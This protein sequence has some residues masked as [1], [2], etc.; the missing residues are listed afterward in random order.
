MQDRSSGSAKAGGGGASDASASSS[1]EIGEWYFFIIW[2][3]YFH[4]SNLC[5]VNIHIK[6]GQKIIYTATILVH[7]AKVYIIFWPHFNSST[8]VILSIQW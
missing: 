5:F 3:S 7:I 2:H 8:F 4:L 1:G 6:C